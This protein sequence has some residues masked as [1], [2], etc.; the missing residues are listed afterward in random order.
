MRDTFPFFNRI[1]YILVVF[2]ALIVSPLSAQQEN[3]L[4]Y[5]ITEG[6]A[7][8]LS[9]KNQFAASFALGGDRVRGEEYGALA[10]QVGFSP[11]KGIGI[12]L[13]Y[14]NIIA[15]ANIYSCSGKV[16]DGAAGIYHF[17][18]AKKQQE[19]NSVSRPFMQQGILI[20]LYAGFA[21]GSIDHQAINNRGGQ[22]YLNLNKY[23]I[24][25]GLH[26]QGPWIAFSVLLR[27][28]IINYTEA[29][30]LGDVGINYLNS[31]ETLNLDNPFYP[32][33]VSYKISMGNS[34]FQMFLS[35]YEQY[36]TKI[37]ADEH[38]LKAFIQLGFA[39]GI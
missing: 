27:T 18:A 31:I 10:Y 5:V 35:Y 30:L 32:L 11:Y 25:G 16:V 12:Q 15:P 26:V 21:H 3:P 22:S 8:S 13:G 37:R 4:Y 7:L 2:M 33:E 9:K 29:V 6:P 36:N 28:G 19:H 34:Q 23:Y 20:D 17:I 1:H 39:I 38:F 24:Q 14:S